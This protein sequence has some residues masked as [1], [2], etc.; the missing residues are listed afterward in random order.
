MLLKLFD[1]YEVSEKAKQRAANGLRLD[2][3][4]D[5]D[6]SDYARANYRRSREAREKDY[7]L[8]ETYLGEAVVL[9]D[10]ASVV[11]GHQE[12]D[13][14]VPYVIYFDLPTGQVSFHCHD[15]FGTEE[16][17]RPWDGT[18][19]SGSRIRRAFEHLFS[20]ECS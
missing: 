4:H 13:E 7:W 12:V 9:A 3:Y 20:Q 8:K 18:R 14:F 16:H 10:T 5:V 2:D 6:R 17:E 1:I 15:C 11:C 19:Q